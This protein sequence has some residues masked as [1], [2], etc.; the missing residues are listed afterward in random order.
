MVKS[1]KETRIERPRELA[2][3][4]IVFSNFMKDEAKEILKDIT[5]YQ[6]GKT[7]DFCVLCDDFYF[8]S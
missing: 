2:K 8:L 3:R 1:R 4:D 5:N 7:S 6:V